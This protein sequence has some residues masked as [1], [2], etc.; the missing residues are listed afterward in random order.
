MLAPPK[1]G[2]TAAASNLV[3]DIVF[4]GAVPC[5]CRRAGSGKHETKRFD[6]IIREEEGKFSEDDDFDVEFEDG[7]QPDILVAVGISTADVVVLGR[8]RGTFLNPCSPH[9]RIFGMW[10][11][12]LLVASSRGGKK[13]FVPKRG[14][15]E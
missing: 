6:G 2:I 4:P 5:D 12:L 3:S 15:K 14:R 8:R 11:L 10:G 13:G 7:E 1:P 9:E